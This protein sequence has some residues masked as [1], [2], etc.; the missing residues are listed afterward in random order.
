[1]HFRGT[2]TI[3]LILLVWLSGESSPLPFA[4]F[5]PPLQ[6][7]CGLPNGSAIPAI[8][9]HEP[10]SLWPQSVGDSLRSKEPR[11]SAGYFRGPYFSVWLLDELAVSLNHD[12]ILLPH[13]ALY[14]ASHAHS[15]IEPLVRRRFFFDLWL[16]AAPPQP[17]HQSMPA[18]A[19]L[20][21]TGPLVTP[22]FS[23]IVVSATV[24]YIFT[25]TSRVC[26]VIEVKH[27]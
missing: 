6:K 23:C 12:M 1:M 18:D 2:I 26:D 27:P 7:Q 24:F 21:R 11:F 20:V 3:V 15:P 9:A 4:V 13:I 25:F 10:V 22:P 17:R 8:L 5:I 16:S 14:G 19:L